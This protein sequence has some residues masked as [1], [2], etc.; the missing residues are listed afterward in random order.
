[1]DRDNNIPKHS[2]S[3]QNVLISEVQRHFLDKDMGG[4]SEW[5]ANE[6]AVARLW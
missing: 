6:D 3:Y 4:F 2:V 5:P 1:M